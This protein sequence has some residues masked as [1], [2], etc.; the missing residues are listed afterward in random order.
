[1]TY[2]VGSNDGLYYDVLLP[3]RGW[4]MIQGEGPRYQFPSA[5]RKSSP[6]HKFDLLMTLYSGYGENTRWGYTV[7][8]K[9]SNVE[10]L[11]ESEEWA[12]WDQCGRLVYTDSG[13]LFVGQIRSDRIEPIQIADFS[14]NKPKLIQSPP[15][16]RTWDQIG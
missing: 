14:A 3:H 1:P 4:T 12:D 6:D 13:K 5:W 10:L 2:Q 7:I 16:A 8:H 15:W 11:V 9:Q